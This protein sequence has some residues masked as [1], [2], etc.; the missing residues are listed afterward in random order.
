MAVVTMTCPYAAAHEPM[1]VIRF[2]TRTMTLKACGK[3]NYIHLPS[4]PCLPTNEYTSISQ[5][6]DKTNTL[7][8]EDK[9]E[10]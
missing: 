3:N 8:L 1:F 6:E 4:I 10:N 7:Q 5:L 9:N 2:H